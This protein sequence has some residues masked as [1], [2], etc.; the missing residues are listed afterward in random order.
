MTT[1]EHR[2][3]AGA[4]DPGEDLFNAG[5]WYAWGPY[6]SERAWGTVRE[7][8]SA[9][10]DAWGSF[11]HD[12][13]RSRAYRWNEDGMAGLSR[14]PPRPLPRARALE[15]SRPDP[16]GAHVRAHRPRG[17]PRRGRQGVLVVPRRPA[18]PRMAAVALPLPAGTL[19]VRATS[20]RRTAAAARRPR[21]RADRHRRVRRRPLLGRSTSPT[22]RPTPPRCWPASR[23]RTRDPT[24]PRCT[25]FR[26]CG[27]ATRGPG[28]R[29][30]PSSRR[31]A[32]TATAWWP[33]IG[34]GTYRLDAA[35]RPRGT[36]PAALFCENVSNTARLFDAAPVTPYPKDGINDHVVAGAATVNPDQRGTKAAW[37][38]Q[39]T[40]PAGGT[41]ELRLRLRPDPG[42]AGRSK[43]EKRDKRAKRAAKPDPARWTEA[44]DTVLRDREADADEFYAALAPEGTTP[45]KA[46]VLRQ[47]CAGLVWS[48][49]MYCYGVERWLTGDPGE[50]LPPPGR[51]R[52]RNRPLATPRR[53][54]RAGHAGP[55]GVP[56]V[57]GVGP[58][59][60]RDGLG[61]SG[62]GLRQVPGD[63]PAARMVPASQRGRA[64][65]RVELRRPEPAGAR[66]GRAA[67]LQRGRG[68]GRGRSWSGSSR[69]SW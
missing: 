30:T 38:Y 29:R 58:G 50:P 62:P 24:P 10:G 25:S 47:S 12:H 21:V 2:R 14:H 43:R 65:L 16:Q 45:D 6:L 63:R 31:S 28:I 59:L 20:S 46:L 39:V 42:A 33:T 5:P 54:R 60:P 68:A 51:D 17:Q 36:P 13:A 27:S 57:R 67:R 26:R 15:R 1:A 18:Q 32:S 8:Y 41:A 7:D 19:P 49:Q 3:L 44:F 22:R 55:V 56:V 64:G 23:S 9:D 69:S 52:I 53:L 37:W 34:L 40:V 4:A 48:K 66:V 61:A 11:P 35:A